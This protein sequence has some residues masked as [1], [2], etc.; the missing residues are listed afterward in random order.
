MKKEKLYQQQTITKK[1]KNKM[2][3]GTIISY[4]LMG[5]GVILFIIACIMAAYTVPQGTVSIVTRLGKFKKISVAGLSFKIPF[6]DSIFKNISLQN[7][8][9]V[10]NFQAITSDQANVSFNTM[11][12]Y[13][14]KD[15]T[16]ETIKNIAFKFASEAEFNQ[17]LQRT[18][19]GAIRAFVAGKKQTEVLTL[20]KEIVD[21]VKSELDETLNS[22]GYHLSDL[23]INDIAFDKAIT[24]SMARVVASSNLKAAASNEG[25]ALL[26]TLTKKAE[27]EGAQIKIQAEAER[28]AAQLRGQ[29]VAQFREEVAK[30]MASAS[31]EMKDANLDTNVI[32]FS[33]WTEAIKNFAEY[34]K[35]NVIF[36]DGSTAGMDNTMKQIQAMLVKNDTTNE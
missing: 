1:Q 22:W 13:C 11:M 4:S 7:R 36:L 14:A 30:G 20:R 12:L 3:L 25:E 23:Q 31:K 21:H 27:A 9:I 17:T 26:I 8:S 34:G 24:D 2:E 35:G 28:Q 29:G 15:S 16:E 19:E 18:T 32:M 5:L 6:I 10:L 33:M